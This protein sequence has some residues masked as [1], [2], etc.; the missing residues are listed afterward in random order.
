MGDNV[1]AANKQ[2]RQVN[3]VHLE[4][5]ALPWWWTRRIATAMHIC[6]RPP[7]GQ[8]SESAPRRPRAGTAVH[9]QDF[10][11][12]AIAHH[13]DLAHAAS[14][15]AHRMTRRREQHLHSTT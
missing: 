12:S 15:A 9:K 10:R 4:V 5:L 11:P 2:R 13:H 7:I 1:R 6:Q 14:I 3:G 8:R